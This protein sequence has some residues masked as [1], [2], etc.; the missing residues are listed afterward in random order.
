M[1][2]WKIHALIVG[3]EHLAVL[4]ISLC[5]AN[6]ISVL[7]NHKNKSRHLVSFLNT[8]S[9][10]SCYQIIN[11]TFF[12]HSLSRASI[13]F[14]ILRYVTVICLGFEKGM[15]LSLK[16]GKFACMKIF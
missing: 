13:V 12:C 14:E 7:E 5:N 9:F 10:I 3:K 8:W 11:H 15:V 6:L 2:E 4:I 16:K 1:N